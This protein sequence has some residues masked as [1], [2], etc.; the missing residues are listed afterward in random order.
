MF[1][2]RGFRMLAFLMVVGPRESELAVDTLS[3]CLRLYPEAFALVR[4]DATSDG[5]FEALQRFAALHSTRVLLERN[6]QP[7]GYLGIAASLFQAFDSLW[8]KRPETKLIIR[9][10]PDC[11]VLRAGLTELA[12]QKFAAHGPG[13]LGCYRVTPEGAVRDHG[14]HR[15]DMF[16]DLRLIGRDRQTNHLRLGFPF[17]FPYLLRAVSNGYRIGDHVLASFYVLHGDT[18]RA[19]GRNGFW[20]SISARG[21]CHVKADDPLVSLGVQSVG[22]KLIDINNPASGE[23][24]IWVKFRAPLKPSAAQI[25]SHNYLAIHPVKSDKIGTELRREVR[26]LLAVEEL[27]RCR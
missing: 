2:F 15:K 22:H 14:V 17:Y 16:R 24:N 12:A 21:S 7:N 23:V 26:S 8:T 18:F 13:Q 3:H 25:V 20:R 11:C 27:E 1:G 4:D 9:V 6:S 5:T 19:L 10:D